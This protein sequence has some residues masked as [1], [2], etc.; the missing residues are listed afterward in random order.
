MK[1]CIRR[2][3]LDLSMWRFFFLIPAPC[4]V[5]YMYRDRY[6]SNYRSLRLYYLDLKKITTRVQTAKEQAT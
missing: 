2:R 4:M 1:M 6:K 3:N 5:T